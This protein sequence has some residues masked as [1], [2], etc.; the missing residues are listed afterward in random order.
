MVIRDVEEPGRAPAPCPDA[1]IGAMVRE[2]RKD[3]RI[4]GKTLAGELGLSTS[5]VYRLERGEE[6]F[7]DQQL[8]KLA[9]LLEAPALRGVTS[10][11]RAEGA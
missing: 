1:L 3:T 8:Q 9:K 2:L 10:N 7:S 6:A 11:R 4:D 5:Q